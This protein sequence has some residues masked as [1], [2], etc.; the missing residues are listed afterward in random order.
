MEANKLDFVPR[1][2]FLP[3]EWRTLGVAFGGGSAA[4]SGYEAS[5][6]G[7]CS[8][9]VRQGTDPL[10]QISTGRVAEGVA[11]AGVALQH[12]SLALSLTAGNLSFRSGLDD[13]AARVSQLVGEAAVPSL[14]VTAAKRLGTDSNYAAVSY[15]LKQRKP[16]LSVCWA[17]DTPS[18]RATLLLKVDPVMRA[19]R[20]SAAVST[21]GPEWRK[22]L[23][24]DETSQI[25][26]PQDDGGRHTLYVQ[27][28][29]RGRD[30]LHRTRV[31]CRLDVGRL[32]NFAVDYFDYHIEVRRGEADGPMRVR[33][34]ASSTHAWHGMWLHR[35]RTAAWCV[36]VATVLLA[37]TATVHSV[38]QRPAGGDLPA[39]G[40]ASW[41][42]IPWPPLVPCAA[43]PPV[44]LCELQE[45]LPSII[46]RIPL[47]GHLYN[48]VVPVEDE[49]QVG[50][51]VWLL[52][53]AGEGRGGAGRG[54]L[55]GAGMPQDEGAQ[56]SR[57]MMIMMM[58][59]RLLAVALTLWWSP[60]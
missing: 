22:V 24:D 60:G 26:Y 15:D 7:R 44:V 34:H 43:R 17:G 50:A 47:M 42:Q 23:F 32:L 25:E 29:A 3:F 49:D 53:G 10:E 57:P 2:S 52:L 4:G 1:L 21:P 31:G 5:A 20:V 12:K 51:E 6:S 11:D 8:F 36:L 54:D 41:P 39:L 27:H 28:V 18:E 37:A 40:H 55:A 13:P 45:N 58:A 56:L 46:W 19:L 38:R 14:K 30:L 9:T 48:L 59:A 33:M 16:E 35:A